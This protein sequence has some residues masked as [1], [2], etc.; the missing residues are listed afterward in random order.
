MHRFINTHEMSG[1]D[2]DFESMIHAPSQTHKQLSSVLDH[3]TKAGDKSP[4]PKK[5]TSID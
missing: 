4:K 5:N 1:S 2:D 3:L